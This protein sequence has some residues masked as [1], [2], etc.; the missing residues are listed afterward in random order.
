MTF[1]TARVVF[2]INNL[3]FAAPDVNVNL[4]AIKAPLETVGFYVKCYEDCNAQVGTIYRFD[5][6]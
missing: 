6:L 5:P 3:T 2:V 4:H 1:A